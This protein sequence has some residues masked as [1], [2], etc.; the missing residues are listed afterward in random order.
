MSM[1]NIDDLHNVNVRRAKK[2][3][4]IYD[5][6]LQKCHQKIKKTSLMPKGSTFCFY[7]IPNY[8]FGIPLYDVNSCILYLVQCLTKNGFYIAYTHPNLLYISW[9]ERTNSI[10]YK[11]EKK[12]SKNVEEYKKINSFKSKNFI[13]DDSTVNSIVKK[14]RSLDI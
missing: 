8:V 7:I 3:L 12:I 13:Y 6:V 14:T 5:S 9:H 11:K 2:R 10:E 4:E 1:I